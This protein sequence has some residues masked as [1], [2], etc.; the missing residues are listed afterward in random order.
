MSARW[1]TGH[2][3]S[4]SPPD[5]LYP[6]SEGTTEARHLTQLAL[7]TA[8]PA[9]WLATALNMAASQPADQ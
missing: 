5:Q 9:V 7:K 8:S 3:E 6:R 4:C 1:K 2:G